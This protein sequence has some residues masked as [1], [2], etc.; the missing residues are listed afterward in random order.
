MSAAVTPKTRWIVVARD[1]DAQGV[2]RCQWCG[3]PVLIDWGH[4]SLQHRRARAMGGSRLADTNQA[5][6]LVLVHGSATTGCHEHIES[7]R[8]EARER[9][10]NLRQGTNPATIP[11]VDWRARRW[12][13]S[14]D[15]TRV[16]LAP[17]P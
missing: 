8:D 10:F 6:N 4:Y 17:E 1:T 3:K 7:H 2:P 16:L 13:L 14:P 9:G 11:L 12:L 15:G 5:H